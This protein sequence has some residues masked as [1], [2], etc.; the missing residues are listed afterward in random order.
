MIK[1]N[2]ER[3][4]AQISALTEMIDRFIQGTSVRKITT[5]STREFRIQSESPLAETPGASGL[6]TVAPLT[7]ARNSPDKSVIFLRYRQHHRRFLAENQFSPKMRRSK[8]TS[9]NLRLI[10]AVSLTAILEK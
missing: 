10:V 6:S 5:A 3:L 8:G 9:A 1:A 4:H 2:L 7:T